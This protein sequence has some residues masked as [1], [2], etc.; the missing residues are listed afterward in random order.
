M[1]SFLYVASLQQRFEITP[2]LLSSPR[3]LKPLEVSRPTPGVIVVGATPLY[4]E[5]TVG[6]PTIYDSHLLE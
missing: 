1:L 4:R 6:T 3:N 2:K 5:V